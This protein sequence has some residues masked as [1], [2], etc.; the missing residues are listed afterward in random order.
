MGTNAEQRDL[1]PPGAAFGEPSFPSY[2]TEWPAA[3]KSALISGLVLGLVL[4]AT[5]LLDYAA[6]HPAE[7]PFIDPT[8]LELQIQLSFGT[9]V[10]WTLLGLVSLAARGRFDHREFFLHAPLQL[11]AV[12]NAVFSYFFGIWTV[13]YG[14]VVLI[15]AILA[16]LPVFGTKPTLLGAATWGLITAT[17]T[18]L[19]QQGVVPYAPLFNNMPVIAGQL[20][21]YY[22]LGIG[23]ITV[24]GILFC[25]T[26]SIAAIKQLQARDR[27]LQRNREQL[28][29]SLNELHQS[30]QIIRE[31]NAELEH[32]VEDRVT[33][34]RTTNEQLTAKFR[35]GQ[36]AAEEINRL[37]Q[38]MEAAIEGVAYVDTDGRFTEINAAF[39]T[40]H[41]CDPGTMIGTLADEWVVPEDREAVATAVC[42]LER[43]TKRELRSHGLRLDGSP[44]SM[45]LSLVGSPHD[46]SV[47]HHRFA[48]DTTEQEA[49]AAK[50]THATKMEAIGRLA[51]GIAHDFNN[52]LTGILSASEQLESRFQ[53]SAEHSDALKLASTAR[54]A[55]TRAAELTRQL[56]DFARLKRPKDEVIDVHASIENSMQLLRSAINSSIRV[57]T[58]LAP[59]TLLTR[60]D[61]ARF[62]SG[63]LNLGLNARDAMP[64]GGELTISTCKVRLPSQEIG[65][66][67]TNSPPIDFIR[68]EVTDTGVGIEKENLT[69][70]F[71]PFFTTK[72]TGQGTGLGLSVF[73][74][75]LDEIGGSL[76]VESTPHKGTVCSIHTPLTRQVG[77]REMEQENDDSLEGSGVLLIAEDDKQVMT[78]LSMML[79]AAGYSVIPCEDGGAAVKAFADNHEQVAA[80]LIDF[81]MP[82]MNGAEVFRELRQINPNIPVVLMSG[83]LSDPDL[84]ELKAQGLSGIVTK[85]CT[86]KTLLSAL[87]EAAPPRSAATRSTKNS[88]RD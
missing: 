8:V 34:L 75:Y 7:V 71:E 43:G 82:V 15:G 36:K 86:R 56:L 41:Q 11:F 66:A 3:R 25:G 79:E 9:L 21:P 65:T 6:Q 87:R 20:S 81:R 4:Y 16:A 53:D 46:P 50:L 80:A 39:A 78:V 5:A 49:L 59:E 22:L 58:N 40:M 83:N 14:A 48:R 10:L 73:D 37:R 55:G 76:E 70:I 1:K 18:V 23:S 77:D 47:E 69:K 57:T 72:P 29:A 85:P 62:E 42:G 52:L 61:A 17:L 32:R 13:P 28:L 68:V 26:L 60:G 44:F 35:E 31:A 88:S 27:D 24:V 54:M 45:E 84:D 33:E 30:H 64:D 19:E 63:I 38:A 51:G 2:L 12:S 67:E 74:R